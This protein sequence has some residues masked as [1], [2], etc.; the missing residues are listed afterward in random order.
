M[1]KFALFH[2]NAPQATLI[3]K[4]KE[5][6]H[7][8]GATIVSD[9]NEADCVLSIGGDGTF[10]S[11][12]AEVREKG[13]PILGIN[14]G[15]LGF[16][17]D[18]TPDEIEESLS[19][20]ME[21]NYVVQARSLVEVSVNNSQLDVYPYALNEAAILK[22]DNSSL[23]KIDTYINTQPL[24]TYVADGLIV[25][26]PTGSTGYSLSV[27]GPIAAPNCGCF[28]LS[29]VAP[30]S[31]NVRPVVLKDDVTIELHVHSRSGNFL[32]SI[33]GRSQS[34][35]ENTT[36]RLCRAPYDINVMK[37]KRKNFFDTL[38][39]KMGWG[40]IAR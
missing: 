17:T 24:N 12:A 13:L 5:V 18:V 29:A 14:T 7:A 9:M 31:L 4:I 25:S 37:I 30:H 32:L 34:L 40:T 2:K 28:C 15:H 11:A 8:H 21:G 35:P 16:L 10:L 20:M 38:R 27:G 26:T 33:D 6:L 19:L 1:K 36:I 22:H 39:N 23:I 3:D